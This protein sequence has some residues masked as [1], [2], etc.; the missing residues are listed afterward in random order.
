MQDGFKA[1]A[2]FL[3]LGFL[4]KN[5][6]AAYRQFR[7]LLP[8]LWMKAGAIGECP[9][10]KGK[11]IPEY[12][13]LPENKMAILTEEWAY[14]KFMDEMKDRQDIKTVFLVVDSENGFRE[15]AAPLKWAKT[16]QLYKDYLEN[17]TI[18]YEK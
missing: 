5:S 6:V 3:K 2:Q 10:L 15:M 13:I 16:Y 14:A 12:L 8:L 18:N 7:E 9:T 4:D 11:E 1:N 17:F